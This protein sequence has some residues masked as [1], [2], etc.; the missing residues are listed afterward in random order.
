MLR[1]ADDS[2]SLAWELQGACLTKQYH[3][4]SIL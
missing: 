1:I 3:A 4:H 2:R